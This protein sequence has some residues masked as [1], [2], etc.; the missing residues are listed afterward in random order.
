MIYKYTFEM[1]NDFV[2]ENGKGTTLESTV[3]EDSDKKLNFR[4]RCGNPFSTTFS[5]FKKRNKR[6]CNECSNRTRYTLETAR[7]IFRDNNLEPLF[8][9]FKNVKQKLIGKT[10][11]G[12]MVVTNIDTLV[13]K[14]SLPD[15]FSKFNPYTIYNINIIIKIIA[16]RY[17]LLSTKY[18]NS[19]EK[20]E[21]KCGQNHEFKMNWADFYSGRRCS[22]CSG[23]YSKTNDEFVKEVYDLVED[24]YTFLEEYNGV[25]NK[26]NVIHHK[27]NH[28]YSV[29]PYYF[30]NRGQRCPK[31]NESKGEKEIDYI[32]NKLQI[33][34]KYQFRFKDCR[35]K[36]PLPFDFA[37]LDDNGK[38]LFLI[39]YDGI[40]HYEAIEY[41]GGEK[42]LKETQKRDKIKDNYCLSKNI[43]LLRI[44]YWELNNIEN[45]LN[46]FINE[47]F[48]LCSNL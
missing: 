47:V 34:Y 22:K 31:C 39:E 23:V 11:E 28:K 18:K 17:S 10:K 30:I 21:W 9:E 26:I 20:L 13:N 27:C 45:I 35:D 15:P 5:K 4:C 36:L 42:S 24:K 29:T 8:N 3:F 37:V 7:Q 48:L 41:F 43:P 14:K 32:L 44:P 19:Q 12:Y 33:I 6:Q 40:Q 38:V 46:T 2:N 25:D 16:P 1:V